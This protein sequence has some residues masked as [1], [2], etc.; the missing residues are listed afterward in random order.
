LLYDAIY[1]NMK[2]QEVDVA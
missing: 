1:A 2:A